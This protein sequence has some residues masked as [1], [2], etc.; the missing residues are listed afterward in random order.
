MWI[1]FC[2]STEFLVRYALKQIYVSVNESLHFNFKLIY[3]KRR[4]LE[5]NLLFERGIFLKQALHV[6]YSRKKYFLP[7]SMGGRYNV[8]F[9]FHR[10]LNNHFQRKISRLHATPAFCIQKNTSL[11]DS[12][13]FISL[14]SVSGFPFLNRFNQESNKPAL[15]PLQI[16]II[17][18]WFSRENNF[19][20]EH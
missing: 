8:C 3:Q 17:H 16:K 19:D 6:A 15:T 7:N 12:K 20:I 18:I 14:I 1:E 2:G 13:I 11:A 4:Y 9:F 5:S 10:V